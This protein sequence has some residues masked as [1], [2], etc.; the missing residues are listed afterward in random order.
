MGPEGFRER[1]STPRDE[2]TGAPGGLA[3]LASA[4]DE[5]RKGNLFLRLTKLAR[6]PYQ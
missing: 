6:H 2:S 5:E 4:R 1:G 3:I